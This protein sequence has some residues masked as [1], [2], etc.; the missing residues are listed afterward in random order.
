MRRRDHHARASFAR[1]ILVLAAAVL[2]GPALQL[3]GHG[4]LHA[5]DAAPRSQIVGTVVSASGEPV[6]GATVLA[7]GTQVPEPRRTQ[8]G[9]EGE[10]GLRSLPPGEYTVTI[11]AYGYA[12]R[13]RSVDV[14]AGQ[15]RH[16]D[17]VT[18]RPAPVQLRDLEVTT[19]TRTLASVRE[20][21]AAVTV[22]SRD[23]IEEQSTLTTDIG[24]IL[25]QTVPGLAPGTQS[26][27]NF[28]QTLR[29]R[30]LHVMVDGIPVSTPLR[31]GQRALHSVDPSAIER[32]EIVRGATAAYG[33]GGTGGVINIITHDAGAD[34]NDLRTEVQLTTPASDVAAD[35]GGRVT[36]RLSGRS[37]D[38][39]YAFGATAEHTAHNYDAAGDL[40]PPDPKGQGGVADA[41]GLNLF[42]KATF[43]LAPE[44]NLTVSGTRYRFL[45]E[46][47]GYRTVPGT[48]GEQKTTAEP[49]DSR[50]EDVGNEHTTLYARYTASDLF[51]GSSLE[52]SAFLDRFTARYGW[53][54]FFG[55]QSRI[56]SAKEGAR[57]HVNTP[58][59]LTGGATLTWGADYLNDR[60]AQYIADGRTFAPPIDRHSVGPFARIKL[61]VGDRVTLR[62]GGRHEAIWLHVDDFKTIEEMGGN[63]VEG[64]DLSYSA[65]VF[66]AGSVL[67]V[68]E[69]LDLF[70]S[71][72]QGFSVTEVGRQLRGTAAESVEALDPEP[73][74][75]AHYEAGVRGR[76]PGLHV[77]LSAYENTS[78]LGASFN[79]DLE[80]VRA[81]EEIRGLEASL[82]VQPADGWKAG[83]NFTW[84]VGK[85]DADDDGRID[86]PLPGFRVPPVKIF[87]YVESAT[88]PGWKNRVQA[89][90]VG[91]RKVFPSDA[92]GFGQ[93]RVD[94]YAT[95]DVSSSLEIWKGTARL[96]VKNV[97]NEFYFPAS[98]QWLNFGYGYTAGTGRSVTLGYS[99]GW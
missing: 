42:G 98:S 10:F 30:N 68:T 79:D 53:S 50:S 58:L 66:D 74:E 71:Y 78:E 93:G 80:I 26:S 86:D 96:G 32:V 36:Q 18:L 57:A 24:Q 13:T 84:T 5:Q 89:Q 29:G 38:V 45:Q 35:V 56:E 49:G 3:Q 33:Y 73:K 2:I 85:H 77:E 25:G 76:W 12:E 31:N 8:T 20:V 17:D 88:L 67:H 62:G 43:H 61:P 15:S 16:L 47:V 63:A 37:G 34:Q 90:F 72:S 70:T 19:A 48:P 41:T 99:I 44:Q 1:P 11:R 22:V 52:A 97:F 21:P 83:G 64:G 82:D 92:D 6:P 28:G 87:T 14:G 39:S 7:R 91:E 94:E 4:P 65:T 27:S 54:G 60:T 40:V 81:P 75:T 55:A 23:E 9:A 69:Q 51:L 95:V 59:G 46:D